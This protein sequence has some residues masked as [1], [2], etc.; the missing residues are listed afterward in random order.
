MWIL[1][2]SFESLIFK[3]FVNVLKFF[4]IHQLNGANE[5]VGE[6]QLNTAKVV[7]IFEQQKVDTFL[8]APKTRH[9]FAKNDT[10]K[11]HNISFQ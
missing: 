10:L 11:L 2:G 9:N 8:K 5:K 6:N 1:T 3:D 7:Y 4:S